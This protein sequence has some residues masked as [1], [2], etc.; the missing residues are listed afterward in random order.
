M[1][2]CEPLLPGLRAI[3]ELR[4]PGD[5]MF[6]DDKSG[7]CILLV[8]PKAKIFIDTRFDFYGQGFLAEAAYTMSLRTDWR[9]TFDR[10]DVD[11]AMVTRDWPLA[12]ALDATDEFE[13]LFDDGVIAYYRRKGPDWSASPVEFD[14]YATACVNNP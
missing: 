4:R 9:E 2:L 1:G 5:R 14:A 13:K 12:G 10:W 7:S 6:N 3:A 11:S 8:D